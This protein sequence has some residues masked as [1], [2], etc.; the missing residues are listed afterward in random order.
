[1]FK[2]LNTDKDNF[3]F[4][5]QMNMFNCYLRCYIH[6]KLNAKILSDDFHFNFIDK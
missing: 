3:L 4:S 1:M 2:L 6:R 5:I